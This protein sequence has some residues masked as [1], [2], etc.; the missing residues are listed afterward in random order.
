MKNQ[1]RSTISHNSTRDQIVRLV[2]RYALRYGLPTKDAFSLLYKEVNRKV[3]G[4]LYRGHIKGKPIMDTIEKKGLL[5]R[6]LSIAKNMDLESD[7]KKVIDE[8]T[9]FTETVDEATGEIIQIHK[10]RNK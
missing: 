2:R 6:A 7:Q 3:K 10:K 8:S 1:T 5:G 9:L 4:T